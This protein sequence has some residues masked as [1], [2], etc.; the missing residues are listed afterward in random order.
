LATRKGSSS[1]ANVIWCCG[2]ACAGLLHCTPALAVAMLQFKFK[3]DGFALKALMQLLQL[4]LQRIAGVWWCVFNLYTGYA[5]HS[6]ALHPSVLVVY[7]R[8]TIGTGGV[9][10]IHSIVLK[11]SVA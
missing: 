11:K 9:R 1:Q 4:R 8:V 2:N 7:Q 10:S 6:P 3:T 5:L